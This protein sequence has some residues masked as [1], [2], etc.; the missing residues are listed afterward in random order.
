MQKK[1]LDNLMNSMKH[2]QTRSLTSKKL[3][4][5]KIMDE[6]EL[7]KSMYFWNPGGSASSRRYNEKKRNISLSC[8]LTDSYKVDYKRDYSE[9]CNNVYASDTLTCNDG[10]ISFT[11]GDINKI[12]TRIDEIIEKRTAAKTV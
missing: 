8:K 11:C 6:R 1:E 4:L 10:N 5:Q 2:Q 7:T 9:S 12:V 3:Q